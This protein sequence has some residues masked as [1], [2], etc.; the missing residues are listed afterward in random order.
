METES[1]E[2]LDDDEQLIAQSIG[3]VEDT[4][5]QDIETYIEQMQSKYR[6]IGPKRIKTDLLSKTSNS[7]NVKNSFKSSNPN[8]LGITTVAN[9][10]LTTN[11]L[12]TSASISPTKI[13][14]SARDSDTNFD[15]VYLAP[16]TKTSIELFF[17][18]MAQTVKKLP[19]KAQADIKMN[20]CKIVTEAEIQYSSQNTL[21]STR[22]FIAPPGMIP[23]LVLIP[24]NMIDNEKGTN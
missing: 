14:S 16:E 7:N 24:C 2:I 20:I 11:S 23:K 21:Q 19:P 8:L 4:S 1:I 9:S 3:V 17:D 12:T 22:Q 6:K 18:S 10:I 13:I 15:E 5:Q